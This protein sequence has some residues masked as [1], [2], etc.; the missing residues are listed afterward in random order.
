ME[1]LTV[2]RFRVEI[3]RVTGAWIG[4]PVR[5]G[6]VLLADW[7]QKEDT[8]Q[9][10]FDVRMQDDGA[11]ALEVSALEMVWADA[12]AVVEEPASNWPF[13]QSIR[14]DRAD[15]VARMQARVTAAYSF[16]GFEVRK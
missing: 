13:P 2:P 4:E 10:A 16:P 12:P 14:P 6:E 8:A 7:A 3:D 15:A 9:A 5:D 11:G 1:A